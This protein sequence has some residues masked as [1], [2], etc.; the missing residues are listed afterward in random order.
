VL[1]YAGVQGSVSRLY[2]K[3]EFSWV[4]DPLLGFRKLALRLFFLIGPVFIDH[5]VSACP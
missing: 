3:G 4:L 2:S 1:L 5:M